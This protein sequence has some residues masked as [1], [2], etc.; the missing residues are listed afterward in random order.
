VY[1]PA[2]RPDEVFPYWII[3]LG[4]PSDMLLTKAW[5]CPV[6]AML[7]VLIFDRPRLRAL[8]FRWADV[9]IIAWCLSPLGPWLAGRVSDPPVYLAVLYLVGSWGLTWILGRL[10]FAD[11]QGQRALARALVW[12]ALAYLPICLLEGIAGPVLY[13]WIWGE[14]HPF[15]FDG[16]ERYFGFR[17]LGMM[18]N[19]NQ[20]GMWL[21]GAALVAVWG[22]HGLLGRWWGWIAG[23]CVVMLLAAQSVGAIVLTFGGWALLLAMRFISPRW[24]M[25]A[26][27]GVG[28]LGTAIYASGVVPFR[29]I[30]ETTAVG[31]QAKQLLRDSGRGSLGWRIAQDER[32]LKSA[33]RTG[34]LGSGRWDWWR[35]GVGRPWGQWLLVVG[36]FGFVGLVGY[37]AVFL[38]SAGRGLWGL[39]PG[40]AWRE[41]TVVA[42]LT[43][44][45]LITLADAMLN[46][47][48]I[49]PVLMSA[50][51]LAG[52]AK[53][54][55]PGMKAA[56]AA[57]PRP[58]SGRTSLT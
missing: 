38:G 39:G 4:L 40:D 42:M 51:G 57:G 8:R 7:G 1:P 28:G 31:R 37:V 20:L 14:P 12:G 2:A 21:A 46:S 19:G 43:V 22:G 3:G 52:S 5:V 32:H 36:H 48:L 18:E 50:G 13:G 24:L 47:F 56:S 17:P 33:Y 55:R 16:S 10:Y 44:L 34:V 45:L 15:R 30:A 26:I 25:V 11:V 35:D 53:S 41:G 23:A 58:T 27:L 49:L 9:A 29:K 6:V 54:D